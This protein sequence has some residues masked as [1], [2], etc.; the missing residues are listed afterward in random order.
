MGERKI[1]TEAQR[2]NAVTDLKT[3]QL[4]FVINVSKYK[5]R[6]SAQNS[7]YWATLKECLKEIEQQIA[8]VSDYTGYTPIEVRRI[9]ANSL[10]PEHAA[11]LYASTDRAAHDVIK[12][13]NGVPTSTRLGT[14]K[15]TKFEDIMIQ[16]ITEAASII[17]AVVGRLYG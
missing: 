8:I 15:F 17:R 10:E 13:I 12:T 9:I 14:K 3:L 4:P 6:T 16:T 2:G 7:R 1:E 5:Q 11:L